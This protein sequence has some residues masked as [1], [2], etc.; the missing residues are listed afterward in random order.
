MR[1]RSLASLGP[2]AKTCPGDDLVDSN[3]VTFCHTEDFLGKQASNQTS[4]WLADGPVVTV[5][6]G[7]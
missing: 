4:G 3:T 6:D 2:P 7:N 5:T 1:S